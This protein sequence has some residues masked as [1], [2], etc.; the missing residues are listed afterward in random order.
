M[1][2]KNACRGGARRSADVGVVAPDDPRARRRRRIAQ[3]A[4]SSAPARRARRADGGEAARGTCSSG[5]EGALIL[6][7]GQR[8]FLAIANSRPYSEF[9]FRRAAK[10][11]RRQRAATRTEASQEMCGR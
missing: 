5:G 2:E 9:S 6:A 10:I 11:F 3:S 4:A 8:F 1:Q 7:F